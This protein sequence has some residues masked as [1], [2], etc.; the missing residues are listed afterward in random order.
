MSI[1]RG[2]GSSSYRYS[3]PY[4]FLILAFLIIILGYVALKAGDGFTGAVT[5]QNFTQPQ[6]D[7]ADP[8][9]TIAFNDACDN[10]YP[11][12]ALFDDDTTYESAAISAGA[13]WAGV[14]INSSNRTIASCG[15]VYNVSLC[16]KWFRQGGSVI[17][18]NVSIDANGGNSYT[19][20]DGTCPDTTEPSV[21]TCV[22]VTGNESWSCNNFFG[23]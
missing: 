22:D 16:F 2:R 9:T 18:C 4:H 23:S 5:V 1:K 17:N 7:A 19:G 21:K 3:S 11:G 13:P 8:D 14:R 20:V 12:T 15:V 6:C 10:T